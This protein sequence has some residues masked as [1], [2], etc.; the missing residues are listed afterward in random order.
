MI[1]F[2]EF[3]LDEARKPIEKPPTKGIRGFFHRHQGK[4][5]GGLIGSVIDGATG[6]G[7]AGLLGMGIGWGDDMSRA[8]RERKARFKERIKRDPELRQLMDK[9]AT[10]QG[11]KRRVQWAALSKP[12]LRR[13]IEKHRRRGLG[14]AVGKL[15]DAGETITPGSIRSTVKGSLKTRLSPDHPFMGGKKRK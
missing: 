13:R 11:K 5:A 7:L 6:G 8:S 4:I 2:R 3:L 12:E 9:Y 15:M 1:T 10:A 14:K